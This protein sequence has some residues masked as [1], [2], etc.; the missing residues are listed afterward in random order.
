M[1][2]AGLEPGVSVRTISRLTAESLLTSAFPNAQCYDISFRHLEHMDE[3]TDPNP[4]DLQAYRPDASLVEVPQKHIQ[5]PYCD[6]FDKVD[7]PCRYIV[8]S[9]FCM[10]SDSSSA[11]ISKTH[12]LTY[13]C[14]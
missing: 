1:Y 14:T 9:F 8:F 13:A 4:S 12:V 6:I 7:P 11:P 3:H 5:G 2:G 10:H